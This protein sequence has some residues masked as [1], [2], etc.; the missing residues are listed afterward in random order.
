[1]SIP[2]FSFC[3]F[4][5]SKCKIYYKIFSNREIQKVKKGGRNLSILGKRIKKLREEAGLSQKELAKRLN[6]SNTTLSQYETGQRVPS[7]DIKIKIAEFFNTTIDYLLG[8]TNQRDPDKLEFPVEFKTPEEAM[9]FILEQ[10]VIMGFGGFDI[11]KMNDEEIIE[12]ANE[13]LRQLKLISYKY[14]K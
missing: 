7:D 13:L 4:L 3:G 2:I 9:K 10:N 5:F 12:F 1:M 8:R 6:I 11:N 14:K